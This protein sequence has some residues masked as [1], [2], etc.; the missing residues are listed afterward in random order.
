L[1]RRLRKNRHPPQHRSN[2][3]SAGFPGTLALP[4][5]QMISPGGKFISLGGK[6]ISL[7]GSFIFGPEK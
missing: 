7:G 1:C 2:L 5:G 4:P 6:F 3:G